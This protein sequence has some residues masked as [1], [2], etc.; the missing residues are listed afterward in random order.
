MCGIAGFTHLNRF[1]AKNTIRK[2]ISLLSHR[3]PD[4]SGGHFFPNCSIGSA[5][6]KI[7]DFSDGR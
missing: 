5:R 6:L 4:D 3:G 1:M 2:A 7:I